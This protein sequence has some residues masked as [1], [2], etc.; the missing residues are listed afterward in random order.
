LN[1]SRKKF[2]NIGT[3]EG[4]TL[5]HTYDEHCLRSHLHQHSNDMLQFRVGLGT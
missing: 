1:H 2:Y 4:W 3:R 5:D